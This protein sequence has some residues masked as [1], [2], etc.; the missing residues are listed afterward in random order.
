[1]ELAFIGGCL[2]SLSGPR[3]TGIKVVHFRSDER[4]SPS[5]TCSGTPISKEMQTE[6]NAATSSAPQVFRESSRDRR[7]SSHGFRLGAS[8]S[9]KDLC[10]SVAR[11]FKLRHYRI[12]RQGHAAPGNLPPL[13]YCRPG[14]PDG[15]RCR[16]LYRAQGY[17]APPFGRTRPF[18][19][20]R[21]AAAK[22][23]VTG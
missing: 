6:R 13:E 4:R 18:R 23:P 15:G 22:G 3:S 7:P 8:L 1:M 10:R 14:L 11:K 17:S 12:A 5:G 16:R 21:R 9:W 20:R 19:R 2:V